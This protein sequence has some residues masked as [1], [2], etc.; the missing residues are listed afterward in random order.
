MHIWKE[1]APRIGLRPGGYCLR[2]GNTSVYNCHVFSMWSDGFISRGNER[3]GTFWSSY[4]SINYWNCG[5]KNC[6]DIYAVSILPFT[7]VSVIFI[8]GV[9]AIYNCDA[10]NMLLFCP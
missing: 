1:P 5:N 9:M 8:P 2:N 4:D 7:Q 3:N 6:L 10:G